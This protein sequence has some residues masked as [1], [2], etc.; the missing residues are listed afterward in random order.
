M[1]AS[2]GQ[3]MGS[4]YFRLLSGHAT[5]QFRNEIQSASAVTDTFSHGEP[6]RES[7]RSWPLGPQMG[8]GDAHVRPGD[9]GRVSLIS[10]SELPIATKDEGHKASLTQ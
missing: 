9:D 7:G 2:R 1:S 4:A 8:A 6:G 10:A 3:L 5:S